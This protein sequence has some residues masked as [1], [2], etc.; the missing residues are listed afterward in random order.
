V[1]N[2]T[3][4]FKYLLIL[5]LVVIALVIVLISTR[6]VK[7]PPLQALTPLRVAAAAVRRLDLQP[8]L[9]VTGYLRPVRKST[10]HFE[11]AGRVVSRRVEAGQKVAAGELLLQLADGDY[12]DALAEA[13]ARLAQERAAIQRDR[14]LLELV[15]SNRQLQAREV[16][17]LQQLGQE[18]LASQSKRDE[19]QQR[20]LQL[21]A[22][23]EQLR[24]SVS[25]APSR[26]ALAEAAQRRASRNLERTRLSAPFDA[27]VNAV[28]LQQGDYVS[29]AATA[30]EIVQ[31]DP[32]DRYL[33]VSG[34]TI[35]LLRQDQP[36]TVKLRDAERS[37][38]IV[39]VQQDPDRRTFTHEV[40]IR[41]AGEG[42]LP[43]SPARAVLPLQPLAGVLVVPVAAVLQE[44]GQAYVFTVEDG[45]VRRR[46]VTL[47]RRE[48]ELQVIRSG[49]AGTETVVARDV[50]LL[51][52]G[53]AVAVGGE[54]AAGGG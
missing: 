42:L 24:Y 48:G 3:V 6:P 13:E 36:V 43:G 20:L 34:E 52:D 51:S 47:G 21:R 4:S 40:R 41:V 38:R 49:L 45:Q 26:L 15:E 28:F 14:R 33:E 9:V 39:A 46:I 19:A 5:L 30:L 8:R 18:S 23:E 37:G 54:S 53:Q 31:L 12:R 16:A 17:R 11:L 27:V 35:A 32:L 50:A 1:R 22:E 29:P 7:Q 25:T 2:K 44:G 10:L